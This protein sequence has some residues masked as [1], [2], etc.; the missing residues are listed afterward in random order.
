MGGRPLNQPV[1]GMAA[2]LTGGGYWE[3]AK[4]GGIFSFGDALF[5]GSMGGTVLDAPVVGI[6]RSGQ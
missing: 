1:V 4:D 6:T 5:S 3:V 2:T